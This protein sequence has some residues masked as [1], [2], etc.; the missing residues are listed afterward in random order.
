MQ[1]RKKRCRWRCKTSTGPTLRASFFTSTRT[2]TTFT[3]D[4]NRLLGSRLVHSGTTSGWRRGRWNKKLRQ[5]RMHFVFCS[6]SCFFHSNAK[7]KSLVSTRTRHNSRQELTFLSR[8]DSGSVDLSASHRQ[9]EHDRSRQQSTERKSVRQWTLFYEQRQTLSCLLE[10][11]TQRDL[12]DGNSACIPIFPTGFDIFTSS[13]I[14]SHTTASTHF[15]SR[16]SLT[17][18]LASLSYLYF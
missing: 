5:L 6:C 14:F 11:S 7:K 4:N 16:G 2:R 8:Q 3:G 15:F 1:K 10:T 18:P 17:P 13:H 12:V 9:I